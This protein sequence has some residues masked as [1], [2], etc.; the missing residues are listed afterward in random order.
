MNSKFM[1]KK[2]IAHRIEYFEYLMSPKADY[3]IISPRLD[4]VLLSRLFSLLASALEF[5]SS[6]SPH[7]HLMIHK[8]CH[9]S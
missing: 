2:Y 9:N 7:C 3:I 1:L 5:N 4:E 8:N 6:S